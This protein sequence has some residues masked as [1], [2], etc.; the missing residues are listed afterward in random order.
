ME[1]YVAENYDN[2]SE[3]REA[4]CSFHIMLIFILLFV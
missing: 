4:T 1:L 2:P 3:S